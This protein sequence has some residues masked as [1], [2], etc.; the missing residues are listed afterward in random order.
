MAALDGLVVRKTR[1]SKPK[2]V[3][4][5][6]TLVHAVQAL[7]ASKQWTVLPMALRRRIEKV[8]AGNGLS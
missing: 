4:V 1:M 8:L 5:S 6:I 2:M 7:R 3:S